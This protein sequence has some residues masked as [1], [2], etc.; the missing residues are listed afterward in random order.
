MT[1]RHELS[2]PLRDLAD[3]L[4]ASRTL[5]ITDPANLCVAAA[6]ELDAMTSQ[7]ADLTFA[8]NQ[9]HGMTKPFTTRR[10]TSR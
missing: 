1:G 3:V 6:H 9:A 7:I 4:A 2:Q 8:V 10:G 5:P